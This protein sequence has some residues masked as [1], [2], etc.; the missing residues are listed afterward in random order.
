MRPSNIRNLAL[1]GAIMLSLTTCKEKDTTPDADQIVIAK[2]VK[3][4]DS[5]TW[6][7]SFQ[8]V[9]TTNY[10]LTFSR[11]IK[12]LI[13]PGD[14]IVTSAGEGLLRKAVSVDSS[15]SGKILV[16]TEAAYLTDIV[17]QGV[18][19]YEQPLTV[20]MIDNIKY[21]Y[22]GIRMKSLST[23]EANLSKF[24]WNINTVLY[25]Y[26]KDPKTT[27]DQIRIEG[28]LDCDWKFATKISIGWFAKLNEVKFGFE[29]SENLDL[30]LIAGLQ[31]EFEKSYT[32]ATVN[33]TPIT[34][35]VGVVPIVFTPQL[36][37][38]V[39][40]NGY[41]NAS[42]TTGIEQSLSFSAGMQ[43]L[44]DRGWAPFTDFSKSLTFNPPQLNMNAGAEVYIKPELSVKVYGIAGPYANLKLYSRLDADLLQTP[45]WS[46]YGGLK[47]NAGAKVDILNKFLLEVTLSDLLKYETLLASAST[48]PVTIPTLTTN[49]ASDITATT[50]TC[51]G[52]ITANG[53][54][55]VTARGVCWSTSQTPTIAS[56]KTIDGAGSGAFTSNITGLS[57]NK[58]YYVRAYAT[59]SSGTAYGTHI[60]FIT[61]ATNPTVTTTN[62]PS[63][64]TNQAIVGGNVTT[65]GGA[66]VTERGVYWGISANPKL[67]GTKL[68]IGSGTGSFTTTINGLT[69]STQ[70]YVVAY[71]VNS[72]GEAL[73]TELNFTTRHD[74]QIGSVTDIEGNV[75]NSIIVGSQEWMAENLKTTKY[76]DGS[77]I[78]NV[79]DNATW[80]S[81]TSG[82]Y[83]W[84]SNDIN[85]K[86]T[87]G[88]LYNWYAVVDSRKLCPSG[89]HV[90]THAEWTTLT[91]YLGGE[92]IAGGK[93][94]STLLWNNPNTGATNE[95]SFSALPG[96][97]RNYTGAF[98]G[99]GSY[100]YWWSATQSNTNYAWSRAMTHNSSIAT[101]GATNKRN[102]SSVRCVKD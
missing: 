39:G 24:E 88:A 93:L 12:N 19:E 64:T 13:N 36:K 81:S 7:N 51:G 99:F 82:A 101:S 34:V 2:N 40:V 48:P 45:W 69:S 15:I 86:A 29:S 102:G 38:T 85:N 61:A 75:Y 8:S 72:A 54:A 62:P 59:N 31:Y 74:I 17:N 11:N 26:D 91:T 46:L 23:K 90:P 97:Y 20:S 47:M 98:G 87:Y 33:F 70:Y 100:G 94:K 42:V 41:A 50:A 32:L 65:D 73:G 5:D 80:T 55:D 30:K 16:Q 27:G 71:A 9:D 68:P 58:T 63:I 76:S 53:G 57:P 35:T 18:I 6:K 52:N 43:Y 1:A 83:C 56:S 49:S 96:G 4:I 84:L 25:D 92:S 22:D 60:S 3:V 67:T 10:T 14:Y 78:A 89:W 28:T 21:N 44:K 79:T 37:I 95:I 77:A 66:T